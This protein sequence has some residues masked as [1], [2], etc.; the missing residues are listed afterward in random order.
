MINNDKN[1]DNY[2]DNNDFNDQKK[3]RSS[4]NI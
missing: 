2:Y 3:N 4:C 1:I